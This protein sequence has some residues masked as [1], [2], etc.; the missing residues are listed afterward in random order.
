MTGAS[1]TI[2]TA[3]DI[4]PCRLEVKKA[5]PIKRFLAMKELVQSVDKLIDEMKSKF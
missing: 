4:E 3:G 5:A 2:K 1:R